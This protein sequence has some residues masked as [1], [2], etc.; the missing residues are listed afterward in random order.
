MPAR[1]GQP[2]TVSSLC[3]PQGL[4]ATLRL[5]LDAHDRTSSAT[6]SVAVRTLLELLAVLATGAEAGYP[7]VDPASANAA[8]LATRVAACVGGALLA[9]QRLM[10][11]DEDGGD[12]DEAH[13]AVAETACQFLCQIAARVTQCVA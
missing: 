11:H 2:R 7:L 6:T 10:L 3:P 4:L 13:K 5:V 12:D 8:G 1:G 9:L